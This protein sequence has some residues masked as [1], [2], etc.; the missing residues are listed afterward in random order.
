MKLSRGHHLSYCTNVHRG[1]SWEEVF[2]A[3]ETSV[4]EVRQ[5]VASPEVSFAIGL[6]LGAQAARE[7]SDRDRLD[8][9][10][11]WLDVH[12]C[13]IFTI[14]GFP[15]GN[16]HGSRVKEN[17]YLPDWRSPERTEYTIQ[18]FK[19]LAELA[20]ADSGGSVSTVPLSFKH[21]CSN[22]GDTLFRREL[23]RCV[24]VI[25]RLR[26]RTGKDLHLGLEPE[27]ACTLETTHET[28]SFFEALHAAEPGDERIAQCLGV[29]YDT[30]HF[31]VQ[32][33]EAADSLDALRAAG[34]RLSKLH[35][36]SALE[37]MPS[38]KNR[39]YLGELDEPVYLHQVV[40]RSNRGE[41]LRFT[42]L[43]DALAAGPREGSWR[44]HFHVPLMS[45]G[46]TWFQTTRRYL[47]QTL[48]W[49]A[50]HPEVCTHLEMETYTW[51]VLPEELR[52]ERVEDQ[53]VK[54]YE[55]TFSAL[56]QAGLL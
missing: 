12:S 25:D 13:Y 43:P 7:L 55:W 23:M 9:F 18:L 49:L 3:L 15:Y 8:A 16:F 2:H 14:N 21:F 5:K 22:S 20:P 52:Q 39:R 11:R 56:D 38:E 41:L 24:E 35:L 27:P 40:A 53:V 6:R 47:E 1:E 33:E 50:A 42:D 4:L 48:A 54:E 10:R 28:L 29:N 37:V 19:L 17:V 31:A 32:F 30:C 44:I 36:S 26:A 45:E 46:G 51:A 34:I